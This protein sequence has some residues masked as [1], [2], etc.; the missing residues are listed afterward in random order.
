M[1]TF[2]AGLKKDVGLPSPDQPYWKTEDPKNFIAISKKKI[3][4]L[5]KFQTFN[6][7]ANKRQS[8]DNMD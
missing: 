3:F 7:A 2:K 1:K 5:L 4:L 8:S 6:R